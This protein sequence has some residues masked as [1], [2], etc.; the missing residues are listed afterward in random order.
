[1]LLA[2]VGIAVRPGAPCAILR[3]ERFRGLND[4]VSR[5]RR[6]RHE[7]RRF[8]QDHFRQSQTEPPASG[9]PLPRPARGA[10]VL[11]LL[12]AYRR[13]GRAQYPE[14][15][16]GTTDE[17][18]VVAKKSKEG[19]WRGERGQANG[20]AP[21]LTRGKGA[22]CVWARR[23]LK[24][25]RAGGRAQGS[26]PARAALGW[27]R[28]LTRTRLDGLAMPGSVDDETRIPV[29]VRVCVCVS[30]CVRAR[31]RVCMRV[32]ACVRVFVCSS[33]FV[34]VCVFVCVTYGVGGVHV[35]V[36]HTHV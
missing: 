36:G 33:M 8:T 27:S 23:I 15:Q 11:R 28:G 30:A 4:A 13:C 35:D 34:F 18:T 9:P 21:T 2:S 31:A 1:M 5:E 32:R 3:K 20:P 10:G 17:P 12:T 25:L 19:T 7:T 16:E 14:D 24:P 22:A 29:C 26:V 6:A